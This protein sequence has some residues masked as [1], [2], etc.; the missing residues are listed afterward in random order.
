MMYDVVLTIVFAHLNEQYGRLLIYY[1]SVVFLR[2]S[3][4]VCAKQIP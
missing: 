1:F 3:E 4:G 2:V